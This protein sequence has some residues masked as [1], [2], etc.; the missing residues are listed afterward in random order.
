MNAYISK[1]A[2]FPVFTSHVPSSQEN[3]WNRRPTWEMWREDLRWQPCNRPREPPAHSWNQRKG[4]WLQ[5]KKKLTKNSVFYLGISDRLTEN[6][7]EKQERRKV[8]KVGGRLWVKAA[9]SA[10]GS[11]T[12]LLLSSFLDSPGTGETQCLSWSFPFNWS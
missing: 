7:K 11:P 6:S 10:V 12:A 2:R 1:Y 4:R 9:L 3:S 5:E 8:K